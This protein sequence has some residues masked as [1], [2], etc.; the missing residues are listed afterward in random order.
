M[1]LTKTDAHNILVFL[2]R[3]QLTGNEALTFVLLCDKL[4]KIEM[5]EEVKEDG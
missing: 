3:V 5:A 4:K 2:E 1:E